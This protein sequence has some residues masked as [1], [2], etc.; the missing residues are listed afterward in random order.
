LRRTKKHPLWAKYYHPLEPGD[1]PDIPRV[2]SDARSNEVQH[3]KEKSIVAQ[4]WKEASLRSKRPLD[5]TDPNQQLGK[6]ARGPKVPRMNILDTGTCFMGMFCEDQHGCWQ[7]GC[8]QHGCWQHGC[9]QHGCVFLL[10]TEMRNLRTTKPDKCRL[11]A[12]HGECCP[13]LHL[14]IKQHSKDVRVQDGTNTVTFPQPRM[15]PISQTTLFIQTM[16]AV[17]QQFNRMRGIKHTKPDESFTDP[18]EL[19]FSSAVRDQ[20][21]ICF[22]QLEEV[23]LELWKLIEGHIFFLESQMTKITNDIPMALTI[24]AF[25]IVLQSALIIVDEQMKQVYDAHVG[26]MPKEQARKETEI[27]AVA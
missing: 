4:L 5:Q 9:W 24:T 20:A 11:F 6:D 7:H 16:R 14:C 23:Q 12:G 27:S 26:C 3:E 1:N 17:S 25:A 10:L 19:A 21:A 15:D 8:W 2:L 22:R 13:N 18:V